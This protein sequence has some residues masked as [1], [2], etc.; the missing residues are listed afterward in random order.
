MAQQVGLKFHELQV[1]RVI[2]QVDARWLGAVEMAEH[3]VVARIVIKRFLTN[4][5][6]NLA[7]F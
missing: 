7:R 6:R 5:F 1:Q 3:S 4:S 2:V